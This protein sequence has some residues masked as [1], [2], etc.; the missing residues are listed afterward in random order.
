MHLWQNLA[1]NVKQAF[2]NLPSRVAPLVAAETSATAVQILLQREVN[3][4]LTD[5]ANG[6]AAAEATV[7]APHDADA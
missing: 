7:G 3:Q 1:T 5:L 6:V 4:T 2:L